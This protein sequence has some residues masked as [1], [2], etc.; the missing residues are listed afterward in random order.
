MQV[1]GWGAAG[2]EID[3]EQ[4]QGEVIVEATGEVA[5]IAPDGGVDREAILIRGAG[6]TDLRF[7][8]HTL[9]AVK[10]TVGTPDK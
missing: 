4:F 9:A 10:P 7:G 5:S 3:D 2:G 6:F 8:E 1:R